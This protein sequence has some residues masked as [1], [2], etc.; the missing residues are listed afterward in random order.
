MFWLLQKDTDD[1][2]KDQL[3]LN[4]HLQEKA[5]VYHVYIMII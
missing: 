1:E 5:S 4:L 3:R 2:V